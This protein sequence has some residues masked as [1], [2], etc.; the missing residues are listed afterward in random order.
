MKRGNYIIDEAVEGENQYLS[1]KY[2]VTKQAAGPARN[3]RKHVYE[4]YCFERKNNIGM[5][6]RE[7]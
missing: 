6:E 3:M 2:N 7:I 4:E 1:M 5:V